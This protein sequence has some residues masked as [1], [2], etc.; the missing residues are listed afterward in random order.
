MTLALT[1]ATGFVGRHTVERALAAGYLV[2]ALTRRPQ[3]ER[4]GVTW[5]AGSLDDADSLARLVAKADAVLHIAGVVSA[6]DRAGFATGNIEGTRAVV[7]AAEAAGVSRF[8]HVSSLAAREPGLSLYGWSKREAEAVVEASRLHW[9]I[10]RPTGVYGPGDTEMRDMFRLARLGVAFT[11]PAGRVSLIA[12]E[13]LAGLLVVLAK[14]GAAGKLYEVDDGAQLTH[15]ELA[16]AI[17]RAVGRPHLLPVALP[18]AALRLGARLDRLV[19]GKGAKL[20]PDRVGY[21]LHPDWVADP[22]RR[23]PPELWRPFVA[24]EAGLAATA[25][26]YRGR[27]L[28]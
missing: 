11:P 26:W 2:R 12:V 15:A 14:Q 19:R 24:A 20:T 17:G 27:G 25:R 8:V 5:V 13:D 23:P 21:L 22:A 16:R 10:V 6:P 18:G 3:A 28:L 4:A 9:T 7:A 1:G